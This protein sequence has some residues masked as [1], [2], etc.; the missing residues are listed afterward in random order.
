MTPLTTVMQ[1]WLRTCIDG[2]SLGVLP[3]R[4]NFTRSDVAALSKGRCRI[5][6]LAAIVCG[7]IFLNKR[8]I[9]VLFI[10][11]EVAPCLLSMLSKGLLLS[12]GLCS[13]DLRLLH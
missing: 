1:T 4:M 2:S 13:G 12:E 10:D 8:F 5:R 3:P 6:W 9:A 11:L 7:Y